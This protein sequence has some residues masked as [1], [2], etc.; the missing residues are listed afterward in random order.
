MGSHEICSKY[1][2]QS[3]TTEVFHFF[4]YKLS[5]NK[6]QLIGLSELVWSPGCSDSCRQSVY[7][8]HQLAT[9]M[10]NIPIKNKSLNLTLIYFHFARKHIRFDISPT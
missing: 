5:L 8:E 9:W 2:T 1:N 10:L 7:F 6:M 3:L 4:E